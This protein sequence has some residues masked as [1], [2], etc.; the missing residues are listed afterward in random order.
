[1]ALYVDARRMF[2][3]VEAYEY[4]R[5]VFYEAVPGCG[6]LAELSGCR[7]RC[8]RLMTAFCKRHLNRHP[9]EIFLAIP[10]GVAL[11]FAFSVLMYGVVRVVIETVEAAR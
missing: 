4:A 11:L 6:N 3:P 9:V 7:C 2:A 10:G 1:M 8:G 5:A